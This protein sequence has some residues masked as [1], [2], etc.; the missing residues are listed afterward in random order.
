MRKILSLGK[1]TLDGEVLGCGN[2]GRVELA[3]HS[4]TNVK[5][6][7]KIIDTR[8]LTTSY[9]SKNLY[10]E[11]R[12]LGKIRHPHVVRLYETMKA[13]HLYC[14]VLEYIPNKDLDAFLKT[15]PDN[16][17]SELGC[18]PMVRQLVAALV[19]LHCN[20][21]V[22]RDLKMDN[23]LLDESNENLRIIDFGLSNTMVEGELLKTHCGSPE[24]A[25]PEL[26][27]DRH[28]Y[29][30]EVD[31]WSFGV[32]MYGML[33]GR[34]PF[35]PGSTEPCKRYALLKM[36]NK[37]LVMRHKTEM[38]HLSVDC[39][40]LLF[41]L[42][43]PRSELRLTML[44]VANH[45]WITREG[46]EPVATNEKPEIDRPLH[47]KV[48]E[49]LAKLHNIQP[50]KLETQVSEFKYDSTSSEYN[51]L[52]DRYSYLRRARN[53]TSPPK[54][55]QRKLCIASTTHLAPRYKKP[56]SPPSRM[57]A[58]LGSDVKDDTCVGLTHASMLHY[59][60]LNGKS[61]K[62]QHFITASDIGNS[63]A[64]ARPSGTHSGSSVKADQ[65]EG[66]VKNESMIESDCVVKVTAEICADS[67][68]PQSIDSSD[69][70]AVEEDDHGDRKDVTLIPG[71]SKWTLTPAS[72][73]D[74]EE[75]SHSNSRTPLVHSNLS[76]ASHRQHAINKA[77]R[78]DSPESL[79][80]LPSKE[81]K[82]V[83][84]ESQK[85]Q[86]TRLK[87]WLKTKSSE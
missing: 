79:S 3:T 78:E 73:S 26:F 58:I 47:T 57:K 15:L 43:E 48:I 39:R 83:K 61:A 51:M 42:I 77:L 60:Q 27:Y 74:A 10:R 1:Y 23:I 69:V 62:E 31:V 84:P 72:S 56:N 19:Y 6:A 64:E 41:Q 4:L 37:G 49:K 38:G 55:Y 80:L 76:Q 71:H 63:G 2:F 28:D 65:K 29:G 25:A 82:V 33:V 11:S 70:S 46:Q 12:I 13:S 34:L 40:T 30:P 8:K 81:E 35:V 50:E 44:Q 67:C 85:S 24:F 66:G 52:M 86:T 32:I 75:L 21:I 14:L 7:I 5:V 45:G 16:R 53:I 68:G 17:M 22:H 20:N 54:K 9:A 36:L 59:N 18:W 87:D